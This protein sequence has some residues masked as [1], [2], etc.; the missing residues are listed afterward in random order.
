ME[1][2]VN[3]PITIIF[4]SLLTTFFNQVLLA[5]YIYKLNFKLAF[6]IIICAYL[7]QAFFIV[8]M[9]NIYEKIRVNNFFYYQKNHKYL[10]LFFKIIYLIIFIIL[11]LFLIYFFFS[12]IDNYFFVNAKYIFII[13]LLFLVSAFGIN[14]SFYALN[15][16]GT[17][18]NIVLSIQ[19]IIFFFAPKNIDISIFL[20]LNYGKDSNILTILYFVISII[21]FPI[22]LLPLS[23]IS[24]SKYSYKELIIYAF[25][26]FIS[27]A[28][29]SFMQMRQLGA[30]IQYI[31]HPFYIIFDALDLGYYSEHLYIVPVT[32][33]LAT[34]F[35]FIIFNLHSFKAIYFTSSKISILLFTLLLISSLILFRYINIYLDLINLFLYVLPIVIT[36][37]L[38]ISILL[39]KERRLINE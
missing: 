32:L 20:P 8:M 11:S 22:L 35:V 29:F 23:N 2:K 17:L 3:S 19:F 37:Y 27:N 9:K 39:T 12:F 18:I 34:T 38:I 10:F 16:V 33:C 4:F 7:L 31:N 36:L 13:P 6:L 14:K 21:F 24:N 1:R 26:L 28:Y 30:L 15:Q 25:I 5:P